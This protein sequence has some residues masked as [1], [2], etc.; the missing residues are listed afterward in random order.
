MDKKLVQNLGIGA[1]VGAAATA[2]VMFF[3]GKSSLDSEGRFACFL[4]GTESE[5][6]LAVVD[7]E[8]IST[9]NLPADMQQA[10]LQAESEHIRRLSEISEEVA[11][12]FSLAKEQKKAGSVEE[13]PPLKELMDALVKDTDVR[14]FF[15][16]NKQSFPKMEFAQVE[17]MLRKHLEQQKQTTFVKQRLQ[18]LK[19]ENNLVSKLPHPCGAS[20]PAE[21]PKG[22]FV[23]GTGNKIQLV[24]L[25]DY[26]CGPCRYVK[27]LLD[28]VVEKNG[29]KIQIVSV[30]SPGAE[31][32]SSDYLVRGAFC[33]RQQGNAEKFA[34]YDNLAYF[35][36]VKYDNMGKVQESGAA[37]A[38]AL[39]T[40]KR[41]GLDAAEFEKCL[42]SQEA[43][44]FGAQNRDY[45]AKVKTEQMPAFFLN[46]KRMALPSQLNVDEIL[47][48]VI[49]EI[50]PTQS[51]PKAGTAPAK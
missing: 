15:E 4:S 30:L 23:R 22:S 28:R 50:F 6:V 32:S 2:G 9:A 13:T 1:L 5:R 3:V 36:P 8:K 14:E 17:P 43:I 12:R 35:T 51:E 18:I 7:G 16:K 42:N 49:K 47:T 45:L 19:S 25:T 37:S 34:S 21:A 48:E 24:V 29:D 38:V 20:L 31:G 46:E 33:A 41:A 10:F 39:E 11:V 40:A 44:S 26:Q 27:T